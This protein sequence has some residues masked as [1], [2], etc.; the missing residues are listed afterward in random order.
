MNGSKKIHAKQVREHK[1]HCKA[2]LREVLRLMAFKK[3]EAIMADKK[4]RIH[5]K[6]AARWEQKTAQLKSEARQA[7]IIADRVAQDVE[8]VRKQ[9]EQKLNAVRD[10]DQRLRELGRRKKS[11]ETTDGSV[12][13]KK[14]T[15]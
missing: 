13:L 8:S 9:L 11:R 6:R 7:R 12:R 14:R 15:A 2:A 10:A 1:R 3:R 5:E 4:A